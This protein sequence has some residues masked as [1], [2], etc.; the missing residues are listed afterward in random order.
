MI[1]TQRPDP[2]LERRAAGLGS[3]RAQISHVVSGPAAPQVAAIRHQPLPPPALIR[4]GKSSVIAS[5]I[6]DHAS[7]VSQPPA[8]L[9]ETTG[10]LGWDQPSLTQPTRSRISHQH[11]AQQD[12]IA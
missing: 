5:Q 4:R 6:R 11:G 7:N 1:R 12:R 10:N 3:I 9:P 8:Q 2:A